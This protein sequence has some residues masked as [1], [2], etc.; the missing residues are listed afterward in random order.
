M[1]IRLTT[2]F[3]IVLL[4]SP[5]YS[6][7]ETCLHNLSHPDYQ[8]IIQ[9]VSSDTIVREYILYIPANYDEANATPL[10][11]NLHG[12][13]DCAADYAETMGD[14][15]DFNDLAD[16]ENFIVAY[17]QGAWRPD[18]EDTY[19][20]PGDAG[21]DDLYDNDVY[22]LEQLVSDIAS[23]FN[24]N[25]SKVFACG[26]SNGGM[27]AYSLACHSSSLFSGIGVMSGALLDGECT[28]DNPVPI[29]KFHGI[30]DF[31]LPY[32]G[33][34][35]YASVNEVIDFWLTQNDIPENS[36]ISTELNNG[37]VVRDEYFGE[38]NNSCVT[39]Y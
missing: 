8:S 4:A 23:E 31:V 22:F 7:T 36:L 21:V 16:Q 17:P 29:I 35:W 14:F 32:D 15:Y 9:V 18:K 13:G 25:M 38:T 11:I 1:K 2:L 6:Q 33:N 12:F 20:E 10:V 5:T 34:Q 37:D 19:W 24:V 27:M 39:L 28:L 26:Y 3:I 30:A